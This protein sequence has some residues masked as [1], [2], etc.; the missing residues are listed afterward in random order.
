MSE[1]RRRA[2]PWLTELEAIQQ[3]MA[4]VSEGVVL[5]ALQT[6]EIPETVGLTTPAQTDQETRGSA[7]TF[8]FH[9]RLASERAARHDSAL[10]PTS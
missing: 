7:A 8:R 4:G 1:Q 3:Q 2:R 6:D 10:T 5:A 9:F